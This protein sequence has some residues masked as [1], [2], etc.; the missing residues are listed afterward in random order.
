MKVITNKKILIL[1]IFLSF[2]LMLG[3]SV[4]TLA[5][6][7][8]DTIYVSSSGDD[9][10]DGLTVATAKKTI[11]NATDTVNAGGTVIIA[12]GTYS[13]TGNS[14]IAI[15][16]SMTIKG[17]SQS[18]TILNGLSSSRIFA[19][20]SGCAVTV[21]DLTITGGKSVFGGGIFN[22]GYL[23]VVNCKFTN[24]ITYYTYMGGGSAIC[25]A[26]YSTL[27]V[28]DSIFTNNDA[29][30]S[31]TAGGTIYTNGTTTI[32]NCNFIDNSAYAGA[33]IYSFDGNINM[34][35][36]KFINN[37][38]SRSGGVLSLYSAQSVVNIH[39]SAFINNIAGGS[40]ASKNI[41]NRLGSFLDITD[42]WWGSNSG[43]N[44]VA[45][46]ISKGSSWI[47]MTASVNTSTV[48]YMG[49]IDV[50]ADFNNIYHNDTN[51]T[52]TESIGSILDG[53]YTD[54][55][56][57][58]GTLSPTSSVVSGGVA[59]AV[60]TA[61][62]VVIGNIT[63]QF[64]SQTL[65][66][67]ITVEPVDT[68][69]TT[70]NA[71]GYN[72]RIVSLTAKLSTQNVSL[73]SGKN[74][75]F[76]V[77][78]TDVGSAITDSD[79]TATL[80]YNITQIQ[81]NY[82][83]TAD[84]A[85]DSTCL[86]STSNGTLTVNVLTTSM[87]VNNVSTYN[88][89]TVGLNASLIDQNGDPVTDKNIT[90]KINGTDIG[91]VSTND[92]GFATLNYT[93]TQTG[94]N[95]SISADFAGDYTYVASTGTGNLKVNVINTHI[96]VSNV[97]T[98][99]GNVVNLT[100]KL[101]GTDGPV[102]GKNITFKVNGASVGSASTD[103]NGIATLNY[104]VTQT[105]GNYNLTAD[106]AGDYVYVAS[107]NTGNLKVNV[108]NTNIAVNNIKF[109]NGKTVNLTAN[110]T[111]VNGTPLAGKTIN[112]NLNGDTAGTAVTCANGVATLSY[113]LNKSGN[114]PITA[115]FAGD[116]IYVASRGTGEA[117]VSPVS[118]LYLN[119]KV[120]S[121]DLK[122]GDKFFITYKL[123]N[124]GLDTAENV[125]VTFKIPEGLEFQN[126]AV[127]S[128][129]WTYNS[130]TRTVTWTLNSV[131]VGDPYLFLSVKATNG[132]TYTITPKMTSSTYNLNTGSNAAI[133]MQV[134]QSGS[135]SSTTNS[136]VISTLTT[137]SMQKTGFPLNYIILALLIVLGGL[138][139]AKRK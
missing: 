44:G 40:T 64:N 60:F 106:F 113:K 133:T 137:I 71:S 72:G 54:F 139:V 105:E 126:I 55:S 21:R 101:T 35:G 43:P 119:S 98:F 53:F 13:G 94:G 31:S 123:G 129:N 33:A 136:T 102:A 76:K 20:N 2:S 90:F 135:N 107:T 62:K 37:A 96:A 42:N 23:T 95:Y 92:E 8:G 125:T 51:T 91:T 41:D 48:K 39:N 81:G 104:T 30:S 10:N 97:S 66:N 88:G 12:D 103:E 109:L 52:T 9:A 34:N 110:L 115:D 74:I 82:N 134:Q 61:T 32:N 58:I 1:I 24:C 85:G 17:S 117:E 59:E 99:N 127:D 73:L 5:A 116:H 56:S 7:D 83:I 19:I 36:C 122:A 26:D 50:Q 46:T 132:G 47:Y 130:G 80:E 86:A 57:D 14:N 120:R 111:D 121:G 124:K 45:G 25:S 63:A 87:E 4:N 138:G 22:K 27:N 11:K 79:G 108:I 100:A 78:G 75:T 93:V 29:S 131:P 28:Q 89:K 6:A 118:D 77:N 15:S 128:G 49:Q 18:G 112:F 67:S 38:A 114:Y 70:G 68:T 69:L 65:N 84:F 16:K 3:L